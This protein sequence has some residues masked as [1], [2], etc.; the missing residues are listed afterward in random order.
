MGA[1]Y[2]TN[3]PDRPAASVHSINRRKLIILLETSCNSQLFS[4][5]TLLFVISAAAMV[6]KDYLSNL[7]AFEYETLPSEEYIRL[8]DILPGKGDDIVE[9][10]VETVLR[11]GSADTYEPISYCWGDSRQKETIICDGKCHNVMVNLATAFRRFRDQKDV[12][13]VWADALCIAQHDY[14]E[15]RH[16]VKHMGKVYEQGKQT[17]IWLGGDTKGIAVDAFELV[18]ET[19]TFLGQKYDEHGDL[20]FPRLPAADSVCKDKSRWVKVGEMYRTP[21]FDRV[22]VIQEAALSKKCTVHWGEGQLGIEYVIELA[23][24]MSWRGDLFSF[25]PDIQE[26]KLC[27]N[28]A[29]IQVGYPSAKGWKESLPLL[30]YLGG[31]YGPRCLLVSILDTSREVKASDPRDHIYAFLGHPC[32][33]KSDGELIIE[34]DYTKNPVEVAIDSTVAL[35]QDPREAQWVLGRVIHHNSRQVDDRSFPSWIPR[36]DGGWVQHPVGG[37]LYTYC[38]GGPPID[39]YNQYLQEAKALVVKGFI[40]D[41][42]AW[43]SILLDRDNLRPTPEKWTYDVQSLAEPPIDAL[44]KDVLQATKPSPDEVGSLE[45]AFSLSVASGY[46]RITKLDVGKHQAC[47]SAFLNLSRANLRSFQGKPAGEEPAKSEGDPYD[48]YFRT[49]HSHNRRIAF[50]ENRRLAH[51][52]GLSEPDDVCAIFLGLQSPFILRPAGDGQ[53]FLV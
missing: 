53:Y 8:V 20:T 40:F 42:L 13:R 23:W 52:D 27:D 33:Q 5:S 39:F 16:Q 18:A 2:S 36:W 3:Q 19:V 46:S 44:W 7:S 14:D 51:V 9:C 25:R 43:T 37:P 12:R 10:K 11:E 24:W 31:E 22:W 29:Q 28:F 4:R 49:R 41:R 30:K 38:A 32:A 6:R 50:T 48:Y 15:K 35:L 34:P 26:C 17:L 21:W 45:N 1:Q 47:Y